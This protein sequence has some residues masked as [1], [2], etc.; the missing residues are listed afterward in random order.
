MIIASMMNMENGLFENLAETD[1]GII[2]GADEAGR[3]PLAGPVTAGAVVLPED[4]PFQILDDS[5]RM[6][7]KERD[8]AAAIIK[9]KAVAWA[10]VSISHVIIDRINILQ[11][12]MLAMKKAYEK[13]AARVAVDTLLVDGNRCPDVPI[14]CHA[15]VKGDQKVP[16]IMAASILAKTERDRIMYLAD[17][18]WPQY[19]YSKH[20][21]Y[22]TKEHRELIAELGPS[23]IERLTFTVKKEDD[24]PSL[25]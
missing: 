2:C 19:G 6:T 9:E 20:K 21:G 1:Y 7:E 16:E 10:V 17:R 18:K 24:T 4:F 14:G 8:E 3:G 5:K 11:A 13:V 22:P 15:I 12:S 23:P 25:F